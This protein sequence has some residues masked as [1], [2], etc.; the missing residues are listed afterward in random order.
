VGPDWTKVYIHISQLA[1]HTKNLAHDRH[2][3]LFVAEPDRQEKNPLSLRRI[4][5][6]GEARPLDPKSPDYADVQ[7]RYVERFPQSAMMFQFA[8]F[9]LWVLEMTSAHFVAGFGRAFLAKHH[10]PLDWTHQ[11]A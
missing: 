4:N 10:A 8:D 9:Q 1:I 7:A 2:I 6:Q 11:G 3:A 5:L